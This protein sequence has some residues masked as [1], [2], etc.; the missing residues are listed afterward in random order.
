MTEHPVREVLVRP[1]RDA[2]VAAVRSIAWTTW[3]ATYGA[4]IPEADMRTYHDSAYTEAA[5]RARMRTPGV[6]IL[7]AECDAQSVGFMILQ[8]DAAAGVCG[9]ASMYVL[10]EHQRS[11]VG[12]MFMELARVEGRRAGCRLLRIGVMEHNRV[13]HRW[14]E[15]QGFR[16]TE[17]APFTMGTTT[18]NHLIGTAPIG[19]PEHV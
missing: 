13:A 6:T 15:R 17:S 18:V 5:L 14:Y 7:L 10:P 2:D 1:C 19:L 16:F 8:I 9:V 3:L 11:G 12:R 4:F